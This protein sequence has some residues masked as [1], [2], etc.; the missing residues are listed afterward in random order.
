MLQGS[1]EDSCLRIGVFMGRGVGVMVGVVGTVVRRMGSE[2][3]L[4]E[5]L[6]A[7]GDWGGDVW[8]E[9]F[10]RATGGG[11]KWIATGSQRPEEWT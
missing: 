8:E 1:G 9:C 6:L 11:E 5:V 10:L 2:R 7:A 3:G 4:T